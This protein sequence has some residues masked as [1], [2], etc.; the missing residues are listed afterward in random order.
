M[1]IRR[2][3]LLI[4]GALSLVPL[5]LMG[6]LS[7]RNGEEAIRT[8]LG[9]SF[10][11]LAQEAIDKVDRGL[12]EVQR[13]VSTWAGLDMM[14]ELVTDDL[15]TKISTFLISINR[16]Y[17]YFAEIEAVN[18]KGLVV[19]SSSADALGKDR[20]AEARYQRALKAESSIEDAAWDP[21]TK[22]WVVTFTFPVRAQFDE[23]EI[24]G[25]LTAK[26]RVDELV[27]MLGAEEGTDVASGSHRLLLRRDGLILSAPRSGEE[28]AFKTNLLARGS[29]GA[30]DAARGGAGYLLEPDERG[31]RSLVGY[32]ASK[33][34]RSFGGLGWSVLVVQDAKTAFASIERVKLLTFGLGALAA[35]V[36]ALVS[37]DISRR[38]AEPILRVSAVASRVA[39]G[40]FDVQVGHAGSDE[41]G[42][43]A[44]VFDG[45]IHDL[46]SQRAQLVDKD[47]VDSLI[48]SIVDMLV[49]LDDQGR[50]R[51][52]NRPA[53]H[54]LG[55][56]GDEII[57]QS[58]ARLFDVDAP[59]FAAWL[60]SILASGTV[61]GSDMTWAGRDGRRVPVSLSS[62]IMK[63][64]E[65]GLQGIV[66]IAR[67]IT[68]LQRTQQALRQ[69]KEAA[70]EASRVKS[71]F[72][73]NMS[74]ELRTPLNA[75]I[76][77][78]EL[79]RE[80]AEDLGQPEFIP[81]L[82]K[83][84][85]AGKHLLAL[86]ND[87]LDLSK[88]E[89][90]K[91]E[92][93]LER[94]EVRQLVEEVRATIQ[95]LIE[96]NANVLEVRVS[97]VGSMHGDVTRVRQILFNL[98]SNASKFTDHGK[99]GLEVE[100]EERAGGDW[101]V[102]RVSDSGI[103]M[104]PQQLGKLFQAFTQADAATTR[105]YGGTGLGLVI[106]RRFCQMMGGEVSVTSQPGRGSV[107]TVELPA[108]VVAAP[109]E[110][111]LAP[112]A[113]EIVT[114]PPA[115]AGPVR[116]T[117]LVVDDDPAAGDLLERTLTKEGFRV[118]RASGGEQGLHLARELRP[119]VITLDVIMPGMDGWAV[120]RALK[121]HPDLA[122]IPVIMITMADDR[123]TAHA[124]GAADY[125]KKPIDRDRLRAVLAPFEN[126]KAGTALIVDLDPKARQH[127]ARALLDAHWTV[128]EAGSGQAA[129][130]RL[131]QVK[132]DLILL[133]LSLPG[134][135]GFEF[136]AHLQ[137][138]AEWS[139]IPLVVVTSLEVTPEDHLR[140]GDSVRKVFYKDSIAD[141]DVVREVIALAPRPGA[142]V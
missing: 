129:L 84:H 22:L 11:L 37:L 2:K 57:G 89:A 112:A 54:L 48:R 69:A 46:R 139:E 115:P 73:A 36:V 101:I 10:R 76:G 99:V 113:A 120:L 91:M 63:D 64:G 38:I 41:I 141:E 19:A 9:G 52:M 26:W 102:I 92:L 14:Q 126:G 16:E 32:A 70:E 8:S 103:G 136:I 44:R 111:V 88:I 13:N 130:E 25:V 51:E 56:E 118:V 74:H 40:N 110:A 79:L 94:F 65:G 4:L 29:H 142:A 105:K 82:G 35:L 135:D 133:D 66:C 97:N 128:L 58:A 21:E 31:V 86:I 27:R 137:R 3:F 95:P 6:A 72:L 100:R 60:Q 109:A 47:H 106:C 138:R 131:E 107:F 43:L 55:W 98:L 108:E 121:Q 75:I 45:M 125:L 28:V 12:F 104:T 17:G 83:I 68:E 119:D 87:I 49:V 61:Q 78:S 42:S 7:Y 123:S 24:I 62:S 132:P 77:Y 50:V 34:H 140:L 80:E 15:D 53:R 23:S 93:F 18:K 90:G 39:E 114:P 124:L 67:D 1:P 116:G 122:A 127:M 85:G 117:V 5:V 30:A 96:K 59:A 71:H 33:G 81:D 20:R 134:M